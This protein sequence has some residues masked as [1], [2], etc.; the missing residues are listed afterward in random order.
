MRYDAPVTREERLNN[1][2]LELD[3]MADAALRFRPKNKVKNLRPKKRKK[4]K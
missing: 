1:V 4:G 2:P 3:K